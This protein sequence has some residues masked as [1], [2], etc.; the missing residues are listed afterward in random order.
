M[1]I[2]NLTPDSFYDG[3]KF[4]SAS[5]ILRQTEKM[6][7]HGAKF[8][9]VGG[10]SSRPGADDVSE[11]E[12]LARV[13]TAIT[14]LVKTFPD[15]LISVDTFRSNVAKKSIEAGAAL[16][17]DISAGRRDKSMLKVISE[18]SVP[19]IMM[20]S[21]GT[22]KTMQSLNQYAD[23]IKDILL[24]F[25]ER[26]EEAR[27][28]GIVD[29]IIDPGFGF[30]K[31]IKQNF[32][33]LSKLELL[34]SAELPILAGISRK[35]MIYKSLDTTSEMALNGTTVLNTIALRKGVHILR[36]HDVKEAVECIELTSLLE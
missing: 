34:Q 25:S 24:Y 9:D 10:Y 11:S 20:H 16:I 21:K 35:S 32:E 22:P 29:L 14:L 13:I 17:N 27:S 18:L 5:A 2:L 1:G 8:I 7:S 23:L 3:G 26:I 15:I 36:V 33:L 19:Y 4:R 28:L 31:S 12:E 6:L 30:A